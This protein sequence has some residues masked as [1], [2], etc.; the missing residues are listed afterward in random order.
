MQSVDKIIT[1]RWIVPV[2]PDDTVLEGYSLV[3]HEGRI[4]DLLPTAEAESRYHGETHRRLNQHAL[5]PGLVNAHTHSPMTLLRGLADDLP[6]MDWLQ[7]HIWPAEGR[8]VGE[9]FVHDGTLLAAAEMLRGGTTCFNDMYFF[10]E[11]T[12]QVSGQVGIRAAIGLI[13]IDFPSAWASQASEYI[14]KGLDIF[15]RHKGEGLLS[16][17]FAP[18]APYTVADEPLKRLATLAA[19]LDMPVHMH[20]HETAHELEESKARFG[21][22]PLERL[23]QLGLAGPHLMAVHMTQLETGEI[24]HLADAGTH[25]VHCPESNLKLASGFC[26]VQALV[27]AGV[28]VALGTD[29]TASNNDLDMFGEMR[30]AALLAKGVSGNA[31]ALPAHTALR[32]ATLNGARALGLADEIGSLVPGKSADMV[33]VNLGE[34]ES[35]PVYDPVSHLVYAVGRHQ[36]SDTWVAGRPLLRDRQL[37]TIDETQLRQRISRW[38]TRIAEAD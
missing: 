22:H 1:P 32:M 20:V 4:L 5:I 37:T 25:V 24:A 29:G 34:L 2:E 36:V 3:V 13:V 27:E 38:Q 10:P 28:N 15:D 16:F 12:A 18:H 8:F 26:P 31:A 9:D 33:A 19:E 23:A 14:D 11:T 30:T 21:V 17:C 7:D 35:Q 6:L